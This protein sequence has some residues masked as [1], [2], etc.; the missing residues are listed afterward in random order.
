MA[1]LFP[2]IVEGTIPAFYSEGGVVKITIPFSLNRTVS[3]AQIKGIA[4]KIKTVQSSS[5]LYTLEQNSDSYFDV[6]SGPWVQFEFEDTD[7]KLKVGQFYKLQ[8]AF[9]DKDGNIGYYSTVGVSKYTALP[10]I[11]INDFSVDKIN[12]HTQKYTGFYSQEGGDVTEKV[13]S[14]RFDIYN[15]SNETVYTSGEQLHNSSNDVETYESYDSFELNADLPIDTSYRI[16]YSVTTINGLEVSTPRYRII[17]K[18]SLKAEIQASLRV[19]M[20]KEN[21]YINVNLVGIKDQNGLETLA[22][23][24]FLLSRSS[25]D[26][27][28]TE[29]NE[30]SRFKLAAQPPTRRLWQDFTV[31]QGK[32]YKY[33]I[34]QYNDNGLYSD[35]ILSNTVYSDFEDAFLYDG[36][37]QLCIKYNPKVNNFKADVLETKMDTIGGSH[38]F[39]L[40]N[41]RT[42]YREFSISGLI[43]YKIDDMELFLEKSNYNFKGET[44]NL[45]SENIAQEREFKMAVYKW[46]TNGEP[47]LFRSPSEGNFIVRLMNV[48]MS[49]NDVVGRMLHTFTATAYEIADFT[50]NNLNDYNFIHLTDPEVARMRWETVMLSTLG[51]NNQIIL[52]TKKKL[53]NHPI[54]MVRLND[55]TPGDKIQVVFESGDTNEI[56]IGATGSY[57]I[58]IGVPI[59]SI[60]L[61]EGSSLIGS[62][63]YGYYS[64]QT[65]V[66]SKISNVVVDEVPLRQFI[67]EHDIITELTCVQDNQGNW[68]KNPKIEIVKFL[69]INAQR[70][71]RQNITT[72]ASGKYYQDKNGTILLDQQAADPFTLFQVGEWTKTEYSPV[73]SNYDFNIKYYKDFYNNKK[74][75]DKYTTDKDGNKVLADAAYKPYLLVNG[76]RQI[77]VEETR[78][79][80]YSMPGDITSLVSGNGIAV[81]VGYQVRNIEYSIEETS[82]YVNLPAYKDAYD[83]A[84]DA[85]N[86]ALLDE[87]VTQTKLDNLI[88]DINSTYRTYILQLIEAQRLEK[89]SE[90][91]L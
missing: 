35:R 6:E 8:I 74:Y 3:R 65:N 47:K 77:S 32:N 25:E 10:T 18:A 45:T 63:T 87:A 27:N 9:I 55:M 17:Q 68:V 42:Y 36:E 75:E 38:P 64:T 21:G 85:Y 30:I 52:T 61:L 2:P 53:N 82:Y 43:S 15:S 5:Y 66:F 20:D 41:G 84:L 1:K 29:W 58:D 78:D 67:G 81:N 33:S 28:Y 4:L 51:E 34:Q 69:F 72:D 91:Y 19:A 13:S 14:Y 48:S 49:P 11:T 31:E 80:D 37:K 50:Y 22:T 73:Y 62:M 57:N 44:T 88:S 71:T 89:E 86:K 23:G 90:G 54:Q 83:N 76:D 16:K 40:R 56:V 59:K 39:I 46:L 7:N 12:N 24:A 79:F 60:S 26:S 70:R